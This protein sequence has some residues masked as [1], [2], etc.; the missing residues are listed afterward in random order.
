MQ[1]GTISWGSDVPVSMPDPVQRH[2]HID[3]DGFAFTIRGI[4]HNLNEADLGMFMVPTLSPDYFG[5]A[6][7]LPEPR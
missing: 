4:A 6:G 7:E 5:L 3:M 1:N 2:V